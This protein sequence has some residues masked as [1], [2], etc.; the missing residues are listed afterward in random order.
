MPT[1]RD[2]ARAAG[3]SPATVSRVLTGK[4]NTSSEVNEKVQKAIRELGYVPSPKAKPHGKDAVSRTICYTIAR[5]PSEIFGNP[6][7][8][9]VLLGLSNATQKYGYDLQISAFRS[10][11][12]QIEKC[13]SL[14]RNK[15][16]DGFILSGVMSADKSSLIQTLQQ[17]SI[18][19]VMIG[20]SLQ[21]NIFCIHS[22]NFRDGY[23]TAQH[24]LDQGYRRIVF[25]TES[26]DVDVVR[27]RIGGYK[28]A[29]HS[30]GLEAGDDGVV[31]CG[32][33]EADMIAAL[34]EYGSGGSSFDAII[35]ADSVLALG[36]L[37]YCR[38]RNLR[39]PEDVGIIG[40]NDAAFLNK[41]SPSISCTTIRG[42]HLGLEALEMLIELMDDPERIN[43]NKTVTLP[44]ELIVRQSTQRRR[45]STS[46]T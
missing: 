31:L 40:F 37:K 45:Y 42:E 4:G 9:N 3:V 11:D 18:P 19:F 8:S 12:Q 33:I 22:D 13:L 2:I 21:H 43:Q 32:S 27:D 1:V 5:E 36:V 20:R 28:Q 39:V 15:K 25:L 7:Y 44:S 10:V 26:L 29:L 41:I 16:V 6:Y 38:D 24:L 34:D 35:A 17:H 46:H 14:Y 23:V 30:S